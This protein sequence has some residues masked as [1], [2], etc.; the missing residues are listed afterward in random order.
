MNNILLNNNPACDFPAAPSYRKYGLGVSV[1]GPFRE[2]API[3]WTFYLED[4]RFD[5]ENYFLNVDSHD[6]AFR[7]AG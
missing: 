6:E 7:A 2:G 4:C 5:I 3:T 1:V